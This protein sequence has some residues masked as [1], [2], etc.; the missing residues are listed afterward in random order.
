MGSF[1]SKNPFGQI[2]KIMVTMGW[3]EIAIHSWYVIIGERKSQMIEYSQPVGPKDGLGFL[4]GLLAISVC[5]GIISTTLRALGSLLGRALG[6]KS[7]RK[8][9]RFSGK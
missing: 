1:C 2:W 4:N 7:W 9:T 5:V 6:L 3:D 8:S